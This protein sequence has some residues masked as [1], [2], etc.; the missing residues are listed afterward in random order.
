MQ[1][2]TQLEPLLVLGGAPH[3]DMRPENTTLSSPKVVDP[4][5]S[6]LETIAAQLVPPCITLV[7][8]TRVQ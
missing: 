3:A 7:S 6:E 2:M 1:W 8:P 5:L 4:T